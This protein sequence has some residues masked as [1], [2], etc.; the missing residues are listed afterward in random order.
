[1]GPWTA[2]VAPIIG[3]PP[4]SLS[5]VATALA[6][7]QADPGIWPTVARVSVT[8]NALLLL[9][10]GALWARNYWQFRSKHTLGLFVFSLLLLAEN[11]LALYYYMADPTLATWFATAVPAIAWRAMMLLHVL[12]TV[13]LVFLT[14]VS[15]D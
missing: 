15:W 5:L 7:L 10:L 2:A 12:E 8:L 11:V 1:M 4:L 9:A 14:W 3:F 6:P 13:A